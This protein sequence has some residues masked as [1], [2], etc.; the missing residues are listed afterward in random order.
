MLMS[1]LKNLGCTIGG[2]EFGEPWKV[3]LG[4]SRFV[5]KHAVLSQAGNPVSTCIPKTMMVLSLNATNSLTIS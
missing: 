4:L 2:N 3:M 5:M 1:L